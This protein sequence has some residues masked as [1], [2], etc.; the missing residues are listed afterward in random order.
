[1]AAPHA[2]S[3]YQK[4]NSERRKRLQVH[5]CC[6]FNLYLNNVWNSKG[7]AA[8]NSSFIW[9]SNVRNWKFFFGHTKF[10]PMWVNNPKNMKK[11]KFWYFLSV[12][13]LISFFFL[14]LIMNFISVTSIS[15]VSST[16]GDVK[17]L[18]MNRISEKKKR[19]LLKYLL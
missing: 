8:F 18:R 6:D 17:K 2:D 14:L 7:N 16:K 5:S 13:F 19:W 12:F 10:S 1:M 4:G 11:N 9:Y 15:C 3:V